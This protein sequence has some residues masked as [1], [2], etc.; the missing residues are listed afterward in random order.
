MNG[1]GAEGNLIRNSEKENK[2]DKEPIQENTV[3]LQ[4]IFDAIQDGLSVLDSDLNIVRVN[5]WMEEMYA[6]KC[7]LEGKK[8]YQAYQDRETVCPWCPSVYTLETGE[9]RASEVPYPDEKNPQ[10]WIYLTS[11]PMRNAV[12]KITGVIESVRDITEHKRAE[13]SLREKEENLRTTLA[14]IGDA[15]ISTDIEGKIARINPVASRLTGWDIESARGKELDEVFKIVNSKTGETLES[16]FK[17]VLETGKIVGLANHTMLIAR[18]GAEYQIADSG[19]PIIDDDGS[20]TG[21]VLVFRDVTNEYEIRE[22]LKRSQEM[23]RN[24]LQASSVGL[25]HA[26]DRKIVWAND[27][28]VKMFGFTD[29]SHYVGKDTAMLYA[30]EAEYRRI[31]LITYQRQ[32]ASQPIEFDARFRTQH[33]SFFEGFTRVNLLDPEEPSRGIIVSIVD[34]TERKRAYEQIRRMQ[35]IEELGTVTGGIAHDFNN[36]LTAIFGNLELAQ[37]EMPGDSQAGY[38][39]RKAHE[40]IADARRLT[41]QLLTF[42]KGGAP[43]LDTVNTDKLVRD[44]VE[45][46]LRGSNVM[47]EFNLQDGLWSIIADKGQIGQ[48][49]A[50]LTVNAKQAMPGGGILQVEGQNLSGTEEAATIDPTGDFV[51]IAIRDQGTGIAPKHIDRIFDPYFSTKDTG[52]GLGLAVVNS[53]IDQHNG[54]IEVQSKPEEG[55]VFT[56]YLPAARKTETKK[57]HE[58]P[59][60]D[61]KTNLSSN[62]HILLMDDEEII[63]NIGSEMLEFL[64]HTVDVAAEGSEALKKYDGA[65]ESGDAYDLVIMDLTVPGGKGGAETVKELLEKDPAARVIVSSGYASGPVLANYTEYGFTGKL[66]KPF[67]INELKREIVRLMQEVD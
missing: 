33:G 29:E 58:T 26:V 16:P 49:L 60:T 23:M 63:R 48:V 20:L 22:A 36:L 34:I 12:G 11:Y 17:K 44:T 30:D 25:A 38:Y 59:D 18:D 32:K 66:T 56:I 8:C 51:R 15:V 43:V 19:A 42:S 39:L 5:K 10:G 47:A 37:M 3:L 64:G 55:S 62:L 6:H 31:G 45:F 21:I 52:H 61:G 41:G 53:I 46:N 28:M 24:I 57:I 13:M 35:K 9:K 14:S 65:R 67:T 2:T 7:P 40:T 54:K 4:N 1:D 27:A 50:N